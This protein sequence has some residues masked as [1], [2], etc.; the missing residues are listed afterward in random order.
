MSYLRV[1][2]YQDFMNVWEH[3]FDTIHDKIRALPCDSSVFVSYYNGRLDLVA[4][5]LYGNPLLWWV[6]AEYNSIIDPLDFD[7]E[8]IYFPNRSEVEALL[9]T[10]RVQRLKDLKII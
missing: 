9:E 5:A 10:L 2:D 6:L 1:L 4:H 3:F 8:E 7:I